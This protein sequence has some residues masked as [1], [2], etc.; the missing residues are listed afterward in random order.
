MLPTGS[1]GYEKRE[2]RDDNTNGVRCYV[3]PHCGLARARIVGG[4]SNGANGDRRIGMPSFEASLCGLHSESRLDEVLVDDLPP[5]SHDR[6]Y[7]PILVARDLRISSHKEASLPAG[8]VVYVDEL[9]SEKD[10]HCTTKNSHPR[11]CHDV[12]PSPLK[13]M[14]MEPGPIAIVSRL[15]QRSRVNA[16]VVPKAQAEPFF[17]HHDRA[18]GIQAPFPQC[19]ASIIRKGNRYEPRREHVDNRPAAIDAA[20]ARKNQMVVAFAIGENNK[21]LS[22]GCGALELAITK[23][24]RNRENRCDDSR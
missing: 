12:P 14:A 10:Y 20:A 23:A 2:N 21:A 15:Y 6:G 5:H 19:R 18:I 4:R 13:E 9:Q 8:S 11:D 1:R 16:A 17:A 22:I 7:D 24:R 3:N